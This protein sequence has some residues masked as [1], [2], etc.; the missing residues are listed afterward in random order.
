MMATLAQ[1][2]AKLEGIARRRAPAPHPM[3]EAIRRDP[4]AVLTSAGLTP[5]RW[6]T[7]LLSRP[8]SRM[9]LLCS[10]Q[11]GKSTT[12]AAL[13]LR[14]ALLG[15]SLTLLVSPTLRQSSELFRKVMDLFNALGRPV[16]VTLESALRLELANG[17][18]VLSLPGVEGT[19]RGFSAPS[20][21]V[22]DEAA[23]VP[24]PLYYALRPML[25]VSRGRLVCLSTAYAKMGWFY[26]TWTGAEDWRRTKITA[27]QCP[28]I[29]PAFLAEERAALGARWYA[30]EYF[31]EF[32]DAVDAVFREAD[33]RAAACDLVLPLPLRGR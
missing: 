31:C 23:R 30:M 26:Q 9:L 5:D 4:V 18:R 7:E 33:I 6:Q 24:D 28:R 2:M 10:R 16:A 32:G 17:S 13:A 20:L 3:L 15:R 1:R 8:S 25:A 21:V 12:A 19:V 22:V 14:T 11:T 27:V 29:R